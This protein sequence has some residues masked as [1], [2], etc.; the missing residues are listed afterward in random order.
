MGQRV[1]DHQGVESAPKEIRQAMAEILCEQTYFCSVSKTCNVL[2]LPPCA[3]KDAPSGWVVLRERSPVGKINN[4]VTQNFTISCN[5]IKRWEVTERA[6]E[7]WRNER[8][9][10]LPGL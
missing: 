9:C 5:D 8:V 10:Q 7:N 3:T 1:T 2:L 4:F 6:L